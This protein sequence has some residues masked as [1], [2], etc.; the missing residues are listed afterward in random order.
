MCSLERGK[1]SGCAAAAAVL[2][3]CLFVET[4][5]EKSRN[6]RGGIGGRPVSRITRSLIHLCGRPG[7]ELR[8]ERGGASFFPAP[9]HVHSL[10]SAHVKRPVVDVASVGF[11]PRR[12]GEKKKLELMAR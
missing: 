11:S 9:S 12:G 5:A 3:L 10:P 2:G 8:L 6:A 7:V 4:G 1:A